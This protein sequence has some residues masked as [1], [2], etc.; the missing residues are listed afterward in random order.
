MLGSLWWHWEGHFHLGQ[1]TG[2]TW[3]SVPCL[4]QGKEN[5]HSEAEL[6]YPQT[7]NFSLLLLFAQSNEQAAQAQPGA[8]KKGA[9]SLPCLTFLRE[10]SLWR[11]ISSFAERY[12]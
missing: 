8:C 4:V 10:R 12:L 6:F 7:C 11:G 2:L 3:D 5:Q 1:S 9:L